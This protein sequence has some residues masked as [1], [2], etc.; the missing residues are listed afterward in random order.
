MKALLRFSVCIVSIAALN[1]YAATTITSTKLGYQCYLPDNWICEVKSDTQH[2]FYDTTG[3]YGALLSLVRYQKSSDV[4]STPEEWTMAHFIAYILYM[5]YYPFG[6]VLFSDSSAAEKQGD[7]RATEIY[8]RFY[9]DDSLN[10]S[11]DEYV[12]YT[13]T[14]NYGYELY[15]IGDTADMIANIGFYGALLKMIIISES[16]SPITIKLKPY[17]DPSLVKSTNF[18]PLLGSG[19][20]LYTLQGRR[21]SVHTLSLNSRSQGIYVYNNKK[22]NT[23]PQQHR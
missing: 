12:R 14:L 3:T 16:F 1:I 20:F 9:T 19:Q 13:A 4:Y 17:N 22:I 15:A 21:M 23:I 8:L 7:L 2:C 18:H 6:T 11:W 5:D 10:Y